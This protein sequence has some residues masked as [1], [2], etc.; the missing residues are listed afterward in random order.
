MAK[1]PRRRMIA[2]LAFLVVPVAACGSDARASA[3]G[4]T[5]SENIRLAYFPNLTH[6]SAI[7]GVEQGI[8]AKHLGNNT[9]ETRLFSSGGTL[10]TAI[11]AGAIDAAYIGPGAA[12]VGYVNSHGDAL[13]IV[14]GATS[15]GARFIVAKNIRRAADLKGKKISTP[16]LGTTQDVAART[17][18]KSKGLRTDTSGGGD[19]AILPQ[20]NSQ[21]LTAFA[22]GQISGAWVPEPWATRLER[23]AGGHQLLDERELWPNRQFV[24][25]E[26]A[27]SRSL[28][29]RRP[30]IV[31]QLVEAQFE[32][33]EFIHRDPATAQRVV[34]DAINRCTGKRLPKAVVAEA[35]THLT[36]TNDPLAATLVQS[37]KDAIALDFIQPASLDGIY[38]LRA[39]NRVLRSHNT[40]EIQL[41]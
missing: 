29:E 39:L 37:A 24:T 28:L 16:Q 6:A 14:S 40:K 22:Q 26:L 12:A 20:E 2:A 27:V 21:I 31:Q 1:R 5:A 33:N 18:L 10:V 13:R 38:D 9:L 8:F 25:T 11:F 7:V 36:F 41:P 3:A 15:G 17:W 34:S 35:W 32:A 23:E 19:V 30:D 4:S